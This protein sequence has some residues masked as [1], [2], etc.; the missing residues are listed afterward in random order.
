VT[1]TKKRTRAQQI[2]A[3][4]NLRPELD[5]RVGSKTD[6]IG[7]MLGVKLRGGQ[8]TGQLVLTYFVREKVSKSEV[9]PKKRI[10]VSLKAGTEI[11]STDV[12]EWP[13][14]VEHA[15]PP[16][17][18]ISD[19]Q[20]QGTLSCFAAS[21]F[22]RFGVS[23]AHCLV[24]TDDN[25]ATPTSVG[26]W[27]PQQSRYDPAGQSVYLSYSP[28]TGI[29]GNY[30][31]LDCG[32]FDLRHPILFARA[33]GGTPVQV[34]TDIRTLL[35]RPLFGMSALRAPDV[36]E[37]QRQALV[38][39]VEAQV[40]GERSDLVLDVQRPGTFRGDSGMLWVTAGGRAA[41]LHARGEVK[42]PM[43]GSLLTTAMSAQRV[44]S[45]LDVQLVIG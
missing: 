35:H 39:G 6:I 40:L 37:Q 7:S 1:N 8:P 23:C 20:L 38:I 43:Q 24:G 22:G 19:G 21:Q 27:M 41:A 15:L 30:G 42:P 18:I 16:S 36:P 13:K 17:S 45:S 26:V 34:V 2:K 32:L 11:V 28:G 4:A 12:I 44:C 31:Y 14:M 33:A 9:S 5:D 25:P 29:K 3:L 10:P